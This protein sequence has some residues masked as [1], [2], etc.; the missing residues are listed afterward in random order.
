MGA[1]DGVSYGQVSEDNI[2]RESKP[3]SEIDVHRGKTMNKNDQIGERPG[4][5]LDTASQ[6]FDENN[7]SG[8][9][10][11]Q[12]LSVMQSLQTQTSDQDMSYSQADLSKEEYVDPTPKTPRFS[13]SP[14]RSSKDE[15]SPSRDISDTI[16]IDQSEPQS[17][18]GEKDSDR[19]DTPNEV[20]EREGDDHSESEIQS[21]MDQFGS[22]ECDPYPDEAMPPNVAVASSDLQAPTFHPPRKSSLEPTIQTSPTS[23]L[24]Q[25]QTSLPSTYMS[26]T[27]QL[28]HQYDSGT[29]KTPSV[30][31]FASAQAARPATSDSRVP[32]SP[33]SPISIQ[34]APP[35][36]PDPEPDLPF[37]FHRF[38]EQLRHRTADPVA[39]FLRS[40]LVEFGKKQWMVHEQIKIISDFLA[41]I[42]NKMAHCD[43]WRGI[44]D[45]EFDNAKEGMEK[46]V[47][48]RLYSQT[49]SPAIAPAPPVQDSKGK[50]KNIANLLGPARKGQHQEDIER[51]DILGQK[52][53][54]Y[55]WVEE[56]HLDIPPVDESGRRFLSLAQQELLKIKTYRAPRDKVICVLNCCKV[57]FGLLRN[58]KTSDTSADS[59]V[60]LLIYVVLHA[61]P[62]HLVSNV[63]YILRFRNQEK[64]G[65][66]AGYYLSSLMG[67]IQFIENLDRTS[68]TISDKDFESRVEAAVSMIAEK[69]KAPPTPPRPPHISE[70]STLSEPAIVPRNSSE[71]EYAPSRKPAPLLHSKEQPGDPNAFGESSA[72]SGLLRTIQRPLSGLGRMFSEDSSATQRVGDRGRQGSA[73]PQPESPRRLSPAVFQPP[74]DSV[75]SK[76]SEDGSRQDHTA[77]K[78]HSSRMSAED[79]AARQASAEAAEAQRIQ[80]NEHA[81]IVE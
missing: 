55:G 9:A 27:A 24:V 79:A 56:I 61:N 53:R 13:H 20:A 6:A 37:D 32:L 14:A 16:V 70:K 21:I 50:K 17:K 42:T 44:S 5:A 12:H 11:T 76:R 52:I 58:T 69:H 65:G 72:V 43:I 81:D 46:L 51:D 75:E 45:A 23:V 68:L 73:V 74:R 35:P 31:S 39:K 59:F 77:E 1:E 34:K 33:Q 64:L 29:P 47:M 36:E 10:E 67:A 60:P 8:V 38:L 19:R 30:R 49:F 48:N 22:N 25:K 15:A 4:T 26:D 3:P 40:F 71:V 57:I 18:Y 2:N 62:D 63:Q 80:R 66:E 78:S 7:E 28:N 41:F 54:I